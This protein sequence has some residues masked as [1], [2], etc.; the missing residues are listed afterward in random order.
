M[1]YNSDIATP[2]SGQEM[3][4]LGETAIGLRNKTRQFVALRVRIAARR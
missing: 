3:A 2:T 1:T 4:Y